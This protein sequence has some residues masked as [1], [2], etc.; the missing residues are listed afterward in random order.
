MSG[1]EVERYADFGSGEPWVARVLLQ[2]QG[3]VNAVPAFGE[4]RDAFHLAQGE[5]FET[6]GMAFHSLGKL[7]DSIAKDAPVLEIEEGYAAVY[8][9]LW[10]AYKDRF[11][12]ALLALGF[13]FGFFWDKDA[14]F[15]KGAEAMVAAH[16]EL[17]S[18]IDLMRHYRSTFHNALGYYRNTYL[19]HR[20]AAK[21]DPRM[22]VSFHRLDA[23]E[24]TFTNVWRAIEAIVAELVATHL[25]DGFSLVEIPE[26]QRDPA[27]PE[28]FRI[29]VV[30]SLLTREP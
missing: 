1:F 5:V 24:A 23:A 9:Y 14:K 30:R 7:R 27:R 3:L 26:V 17:A 21:V 25:P 28:R 4:T 12:K 16:P 6:L 13:D 15:E 19:E 10:Q 18:L 11:Q 2:W 20:D 22:L 29:A 8:G